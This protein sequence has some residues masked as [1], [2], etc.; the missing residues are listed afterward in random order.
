MFCI[1]SWNTRVK[2]ISNKH[3][4]TKIYEKNAKKLSMFYKQIYLG[5]EGKFLRD[6]F[7]IIHSRGK[8]FHAWGLCRIHFIFERGRW[9]QSIY[10]MAGV[11]V[12]WWCNAPLTTTWHLSS[13]CQ[14][15]FT[16]VAGESIKLIL[17]HRNFLTLNRCGTLHTPP[18]EIQRP[19]CAHIHIYKPP[20]GLGALRGSSDTI[21]NVPDLWVGSP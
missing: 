21:S 18:S 19:H 5:F 13:C 9:C 11:R 6:K 15:W 12:I 8:G 10:V 4:T 16:Q 17:N 2:A 14:K 7:D 20:T 1:N 3:I